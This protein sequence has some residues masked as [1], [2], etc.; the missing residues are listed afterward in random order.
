[1]FD[2]KHLVM[3]VDFW[4]E[5]ESRKPKSYFNVGQTI[6]IVDFV[7]MQW[8]C[9]VCMLL[10]LCIAFTTWLMYLCINEWISL[11]EN[12]FFKLQ[13]KYIFIM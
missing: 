1:M 5:L 3:S 13:K 4:C 6:A 7:S 11:L 2:V 10:L 12:C 8:H 9:I